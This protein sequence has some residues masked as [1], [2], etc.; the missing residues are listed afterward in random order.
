MATK[1]PAD[2]S[3]KTTAEQVDQPKVE[4]SPP[5]AMD[6]HPIATAPTV[7]TGRPVIVGNKSMAGDPM[8]SLNKP[9]PANS[10]TAGANPSGDATTAPVVGRHEKTI[11]PLASNTGDESLSDENDAVAKSVEAMNTERPNDTEQTSENSVKASKTDASQTNDTRDE[12][13]GKQAKADEITA[14]IKPSIEPKDKSSSSSP[15]EDSIKDESENADV[16]SVE[17][18]T[19]P[20]E[21]TAE[22]MRE[23]QIETLIQKK[24]YVVPIDKTG[25]RRHNAVLVLL[26]TTILAVIVL[27]FLLDFGI[28]TIPGAP[29]TNIF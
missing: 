22:Q 9:Q 4:S 21:K 20:Q 1:K 18:E 15:I 26:L 6:I 11:S 29:S 17:A 7:A 27:N 24:T 3:A 12:E 19:A 14:P 10:A 13:D 28:V 5:K 16:P 25:R 8:L 23:A 2:T